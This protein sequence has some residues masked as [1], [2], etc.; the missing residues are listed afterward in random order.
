M[1]PYVS[2]INGVKRLRVRSLKKD[3]NDNLYGIKKNKKLSSKTTKY[4]NYYF[5]KKKKVEEQIAFNKEKK[6][7]LEYTPS[8]FQVIY[9]I[10]DDKLL[11]I[12]RCNLLE[13]SSD[14]K[15]KENKLSIIKND[16]ENNE[17]NTEYFNTI[18]NEE[19]RDCLENVANL[20]RVEKNDMYNTALQ[21]TGM[22]S[23]QPCV[24]IRRDKMLKDLKNMDI[25]NNIMDIKKN[26]D[27]C[28]IYL[29][30]SL[31][32]IYHENNYNYLILKIIK[33]MKYTI[34]GM[35]IKVLSLILFNLYKYYLM[36]Y[37]KKVYE[38]DGK[39][40]FKS[41]LNMFYT[42]DHGLIN[43]NEQQSGFLNSNII[44]NFLISISYDIKKNLY[45]ETSMSV[46]SRIIFVYSFFLD[47]DYK[48]FELLIGRIFSSLKM[49]RKKN[50]NE[51]SISI[52]RTRIE[53]I[54]LIALSFEKLKLYSAKFT[55]LHSYIL[56]R[57]VNRLIKYAEKVL[58]VNRK[59]KILQ[60]K[61]LKHINLFPM[62]SREK[63]YVKL[64]LIDLKDIFIYLYI[65]NKNNIKNN[66]FIISILKYAQIFFKPNFENDK[67]S[68][69]YSYTQNVA[70]KKKQVNNK[71]SYLQFYDKSLDSFRD[72]SN[73]SSMRNVSNLW[74]CANTYDSGRIS[75]LNSYKSIVL[76]KKKNK[77][78]NKML[79]LYSLYI[80]NKNGRQKRLANFHNNN[81]DISMGKINNSNFII[82]KKDIN[83][84][85][86]S[87]NGDDVTK[88]NDTDGVLPFVMTNKKILNYHSVDLICMSIFLNYLINYDYIFM[89]KFETFNF[90]TKLYI[91][92]VR[93]TNLKDI[94]FFYLFRI[95]EINRK[96][97][98]YNNF[99]TK[100]L[101]S[102]IYFKCK[103]TITNLGKYSCKINSQLDTLY[104]QYTFHYLVKTYIELLK[105]K[106]VDINLFN[107]IN[108]CLSTFLEKTKMGETNYL[109]L[110][111][112]LKLLCLLSGNNKH[113]GWETKNEN[114]NYHE[115]YSFYVIKNLENTNWGTLSNEYVI[116]FFKYVN[117]LTKKKKHFQSHD[118]S[119]TKA[120]QVYKKLCTTINERI[121]NFNFL[122][123]I[124]LYL[125]SNHNFRNKI[126]FSNNF[127]KNLLQHS[128]NIND[129]IQDDNIFVPIFKMAML[130][131]CLHLQRD[132][133]NGSKLSKN[134]DS[135]KKCKS[136]TGVLN[137]LTLSKE[138][139]KNDINQIKKKNIYVILMQSFFCLTTIF[140]HNRWVCK[141]WKKI[142]LIRKNTREISRPNNTKISCK[143]VKNLFE[144]IN[145]ILE[146]GWVCNN[147][148]KNFLI[149]IFLLY[150]NNIVIKNKEIKSRF[151]KK[152]E[153]KLFLQTSE[154]YINELHKILNSPLANS[155]I[156]YTNPLLLFFLFKYNTFLINYKNRK[157]KNQAY[158]SVSSPILYR[159]LVSWENDHQLFRTLYFATV[160][161]PS[162]LS[163][164]DDTFLCTPWNY[165]YSHSTDSVRH[166][167]APGLAK[168]SEN[169]KSA[170]Y[171]NVKN[172][173][174][175]V[176]ILQ[177]HYD[178]NSTN[179]LYFF[180]C[181][182]KEIE[183]SLKMAL[184]RP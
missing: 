28:N 69:T 31:I 164:Y 11:N 122:E 19:V 65:I 169:N 166:H 42:L 100:L 86:L 144:M 47:K 29:I 183:H 37:I 26:N 90:L 30:T 121:Y 15:N 49:K 12:K 87:K 149:Y 163:I 3:I 124:K 10:K 68:H 76:K 127:L 150:F 110:H 88:E 115:R 113:R 96:L 8:L 148:D 116:K 77:K 67:K 153:G 36:C 118:E 95:F 157:S 102:S 178:T 4:I 20:N 158:P 99:L 34:N 45:N 171:Y 142:K 130:E 84:M 17:I 44:K 143:V 27:V 75:I 13:L 179:I 23:V 38:K 154:K 85:E 18:S 63:M 151:F 5:C 1:F 70:R 72:S 58:L 104:G 132:Y 146:K 32:N 41:Y 107:S 108:K 91:D 54:S 111:K 50:E 131:I 129:K 48:L 98:I 21:K 182:K 140:K 33:D 2:K 92:L 56:L 55:L 125:Y 177:N 112:F 105:S 106:I 172:W 6:K 59:K 57:K 24:N 81:N 145:T 60:K 66:R 61:N 167:S 40:N 174:S 137:L 35:N 176:S 159:N 97:N 136:W 109:T 175:L 80:A 78:I 120:E 180:I 160:H 170:S 114:F 155:S 119:W 73:L 152:N 16:E 181:R 103:Q 83:K 74:K 141:N 46:L 89:K 14:D 64:P 51:S 25:V 133:K 184:M 62:H 123:M 22:S 126:F 53:N 135:I 161:N 139:I 52:A 128:N 79:A 168:Y 82:E 7:K 39:I 117:S 93:K 173:S 43:L 71:T 156:A 101:Y 162:M 94:H 9:N 165:L 147:D 134:V 138:H